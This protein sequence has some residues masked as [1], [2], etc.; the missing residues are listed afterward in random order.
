MDPEIGR[1]ACYVGL[2]RLGRFH[3]AFDSGAEFLP[4]DGEVIVRLQVY[5]ELCTCSE[6]AAEPQSGFRR[7]RA[8][9][10]HDVRY[11]VRRN[12]QFESECIRG[13]PTRCKFGSEGSAWMDRRHVYAA[14]KLEDLGIHH[15][16][17]NFIDAC[18]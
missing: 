15:I 1:I 6:A 13:E 16:R 11:P 3:L 17:T 4:G 14:G 9:A 10:A 18:R 12:S 7:Y 2:V 5:P 8:L